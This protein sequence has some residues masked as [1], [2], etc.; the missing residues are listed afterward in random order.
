MFLK[1]FIGLFFTTSTVMASINGA[2]SIYDSRTSKTKK[3]RELVIELANSNAHYAAIPW[4]KEFLISS[5]SALD[6]KLE[7]AFDKILTH[8]GVKQFESLPIKYL[9]NSNSSSLSYLV[10]KKYYKQKNYNKALDYVKKINANHPIYPFA[11]HLTA[12]IY[13]ANGDQKNAISYFKDCERSS[14]S[15]SS[16]ESGIRKRQLLLNKDYCALG[17]SRSYF[18]DK[19]YSQAELSYLDIP[20]S[21]PVWP[22]ILFEEAWTSFYLNNYN[23]TLGKLV[24]YKAP[25]FDYVFNPE[26]E[27]LSAMAYL[28][29]CLYDDAKKVSDQFWDNNLNET[30][31][32]RRFLNSRGNN[33]AF[34]YRL[35]QD[36]EKTGNANTKMLAKMLKSIDRDGAYIEIKNSLREA[37]LEFSEIKKL[38][39][40]KFRR[41]LLSNLEDV[42][43]TQK[44]IIGSYVRASLV[45]KYAQLYR[46]FEGMS[47][48]KL[49]ILQRLKDK[50]YSFSENKSQKR[51]DEK[52]LERNQK[53]YFWDFNGEFWADELGDYVFALKSECR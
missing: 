35:M 14:N 41:V 42:I 48:I 51:G 43:D 1:L 36:F 47:Y 5:S 25:V 18:A 40:S 33:S 31:D 30:K 39:N 10:A 46:T 21:S 49:E 28:R 4:M 44:R 17:V 11:N 22:E 16:S 6:N 32:I 9:L 3:Y 53:Q 38:S 37:F 24:T 13:A 52:F 45:S 27:V 29:L 34:Y 7:K 50:L 2:K 26:I 12:N 8:T 19:N 20:K 15:R 23:R